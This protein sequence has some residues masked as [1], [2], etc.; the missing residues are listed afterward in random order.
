MPEPFHPDLRAARFLPRAAVGPR[1]L[2]LV[3]RLSGLG[4]G[5]SPSDVQ[6][7]PVAEGVTA[8]VF[9][10]A[11]IRHPVPGLVWIHG[12]G[13][14]IGSASM[15]DAFCR[16]VAG[17]VGAVVASVEYRLAP[18]H[19]FPTPLEDCYSVLGWLAEQVEVDAA[20]IAVGGASAGGGLAAAL[21]LLAKERGEVGPR[22]QLL[23]YPMLDD[24]SAA[25][26]DLDETRMRMW[27]RASNEFGWRAYLGAAFGA[28]VPPLAVPA[29]Y[30]DLSDLPPAWIGVGT[31]DL[32]HAEDLA[33]A[34]R[35][36]QAGVEVEVLEVPGAYHG[37]DM[38]QRKAP[39]SRRFAAAQITALAAA[40]GTG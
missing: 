9:R 35:L 40:L 12:G 17:Q 33:Y 10:P 30:P 2:P 21:A 39:V 36:R 24:R 29:R 6:V 18:E 19:P 34:A 20:R 26:T 8:R 38:V 14:V 1:T 15:D 28:E 32:F 16:R 37:F 31:N 5:R 27:N 11:S 4:A 13:L 25:R 7:V 22:F 3:R 23:V